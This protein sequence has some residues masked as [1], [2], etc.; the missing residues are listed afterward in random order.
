MKYP[1]KSKTALLLTLLV[2]TA[3]SSCV[4][5]PGT[6]NSGNSTSVE[7]STGGSSTSSEDWGEPTDDGTATNLIVNNY[8]PNSQQ[9]NIWATGRLETSLKGTGGI[10]LPEN[11]SYGSLIEYTVRPNATETV[12][13]NSRG[14][15]YANFLNLSTWYQ[16]PNTM[17]TNPAPAGLHEKYK[18]IDWSDAS[19]RFWMYN[20]SDLDVGVYGTDND[21]DNR[22]TPGM[23][24]NEPTIRNEGTGKKIWT[25]RAKEWAQVTISLKKYCNVTKDVL[26]DG[27]YEDYNIKLWL[28][29]QDERVTTETCT[30][31]ETWKFYMMGFEF[32]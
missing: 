26:A 2:T 28:S 24:E 21:F 29:F 8:T 11:T 31:E 25:L 32:I 18:D 4:V 10:S 30:G 23:V 7:S 1:K 16:A 22:D 15:Y 17:L 9:I 6:G 27:A 20:A 5:L 13:G 3:L 19:I 12:K 14:D